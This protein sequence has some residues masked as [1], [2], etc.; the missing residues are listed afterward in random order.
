[1]PD[2]FEISKFVVSNPGSSSSNQGILSQTSDSPPALLPP[3]DNKPALAEEG[4]VEFSKGG[5]QDAQFYELLNRMQSATHSINNVYREL[6]AVEKRLHDRHDEQNNKNQPT[7]PQAQ[8]DAMD[9]RILR[10]ENLVQKIQND[11]EGRDY[12]EHLTTLERSLQ[13]AR[14]TML[15][16]LPESISHSKYIGHFY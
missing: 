12:K 14:T 6:V 7:F 4:K 13:E 15:D 9:Q 3:I 2:S 11:V 5:S 8:I 16:N 10:I 1:M